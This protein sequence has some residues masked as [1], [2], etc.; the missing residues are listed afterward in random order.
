[1]PRSVQAGNQ[2]LAEERDRGSGWSGNRDDVANGRVGDRGAGNR[3]GRQ[4]ACKA[5]DELSDEVTSRVRG[6]HAPEPQEGRRDG[7]IQVRAGSLPP[8]E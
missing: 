2:R 1:M 3:P 7:G 5:A 6:L 8:G 4:H